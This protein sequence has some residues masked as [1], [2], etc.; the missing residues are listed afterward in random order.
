MFTACSTTKGVLGTDRKGVKGTWTLNNIRFDGISANTK[1]KA[2]VFDDVTYTCLQNS[3]WDLPNSGKGSYTITDG[4]ADCAAG[5]RFILW[6]L[7]KDGDIQYFQFKHVDGGVKP[8]NVTTGYR[9][10]ITSLSDNT[11]QLRSPVSFEGKTIYIVYD[12]S[13]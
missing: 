12:F 3:T 10:E 4:G 7:Q 6:S 9:M 2:T 8:K 5:Q 1:F 11:M 13:R